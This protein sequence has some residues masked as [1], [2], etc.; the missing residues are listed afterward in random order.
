MSRLYGDAQRALQDKFGVRQLADIVEQAVV[1]DTVDEAVKAFIEARDMFFLSTVDHNGRP[2]V[3]YKGGDPGFVR[4][5]DDRTL[6]FPSYDGNSM[7]LSMGNISA[8]PF[9]GLLFIDFQNPHRIR[10]QGQATLHP[11]DELLADYK[12]AE[13]IVRVKIT[14]LFQNCPR[15][16]HKLENV[17]ASKYVPRESEDTPLPDWKRIDLLQDSLP[18]KDRSKVDKYG[19][20]LTIQEHD[21]L[22]SRDEK[23]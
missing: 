18:P 10:V 7:Y 6:A 14:E 12:E 21:A 19:G 13:F 22:T 8:N 16:I 5:V 20:T 17:E 9:V 15:Y 23:S 1:R 3:S 2:T 11:D 4:V